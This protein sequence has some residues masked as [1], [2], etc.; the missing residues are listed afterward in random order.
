VRN[1]RK[2]TLLDYFALQQ[3]FPYE[4]ANAFSNR[5]YVKFRIFLGLPHGSPNLTES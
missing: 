3:H 5:L 2:R 1:A 4:V